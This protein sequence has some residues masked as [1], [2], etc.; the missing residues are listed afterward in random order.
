MFQN[1][2]RY[3][4]QL[5]NLLVKFA[6]FVRQTDSLPRVLVHGTQRPIQLFEGD[7]CFLLRQFHAWCRRRYGGDVNK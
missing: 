2:P 1:G 4:E 6:T 5:R 3:T 7:G